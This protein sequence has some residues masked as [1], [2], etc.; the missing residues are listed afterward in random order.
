MFQLRPGE[1]PKWQI[2][3]IR[4]ETVF[5]GTLR[6]CEDWLDLQENVSR[7]HRQPFAQMATLVRGL[8]GRFPAR[9]SRSVTAG[10]SCDFPRSPKFR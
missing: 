6:Q 4:D 5:T 2:V 10:E 1:A 3:N 7:P 8:F 9:T